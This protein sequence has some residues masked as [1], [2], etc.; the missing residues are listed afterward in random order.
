MGDFWRSQPMKLI[1]L[2]IQLDAATATVDE[3]GQLGMI[4]F[5]DLNPHVN[6]FQRNFVAQVKAADEMARKLR[7][8][9]KHIQ[10]MNREADDEEGCPIIEIDSG[11]IPVI[12]PTIGDLANQLDELEAELVD[13]NT[14]YE[15]MVRRNNRYVEYKHV[16]NKNADFFAEASADDLNFG[17]EDVYYDEDHMKGMLS[18]K[19]GVIERKSFHLFQQ[20]IFRASRGN[21]F[22]KFA[23]I[24]EQLKDPSTGDMQEKNVFIIFFQASDVL[25]EKIN[26]IC[27]SFTA[28]LYHVP[29]SREERME[30]IDDAEE[31]LQDLRVALSRTRTARY[32]LLVKIAQDIKY[33]NERVIKEK[34]IHHTMNKFN[35]DLG[36]KCLIA[37]GW[38]PA[39]SLDSIHIALRR[40][41]QKSNTD[42]DSS[43]FQ[44]ISTRDTP[45]TYFETNKF[46]Y[47][48]QAIVNSYGVPRYREINPAV[49]TCITFP[50]QF[51]VMFG[52]V[53]HGILMLLIALYMLYKEK[54][55][56]KKGIPEMFEMV[57]AGRYIIFLMALFSIYC[58]A[59]YNEFFSVPMDLFGTNWYLNGNVTYWYTPNRAY[60]F[61]VDPVWKGA[62]NELLYYNSLKMKM[63]VILGVTHMLTGLLFKAMNGVYF[64]KKEDIWFEFLPQLLFLSSVFGYLCFLIF[65]KWTI[66][67]IENDQSHDSP[68]TTQSAPLLLNVL[69]YMF[70]PTKNDTQALYS[71][72]G[73]VQ[74]ILAI[75]ALICIPWMLIPK[76]LYLWWKANKQDAY[77]PLGQNEDSESGSDSHDEHDM[78]EIVVHQSLETIEF[79]LSTISHTASY[80]RLWALSL[81]H[82]ELSTVFWEMMFAP[83]LSLGIITGHPYLSIIGGI[84]GFAAWFVAT[85]LVLMGMESLSAFLHALRLHWVE[86]Q[87]KF[88]FGDGKEFIPFS[89]E[90][91]LNGDDEEI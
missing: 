65:F 43:F 40:A 3:L 17:D 75:L 23:E 79:V 4:Q 44:E 2:F 15:T 78:G 1:R 32:Q 61:G 53:G 14:Y 64:D 25:E 39:N 69:I 59:I 60:P 11:R 76:P 16:L 48:F 35:Y 13:T 87:S 10:D 81:A 47:G 70:L 49:F 42:V 66:P 24:D 83:A 12:E 41:R 22:M 36:R 62:D 6:A 37:E 58:G 20:I 51:G 19:S 89:F 72:Q 67:F 85:M 18:W 71:G 38:C 68:L 31:Q 21:V 74:G 8:F 90:R 52:D 63:S 56:I 46:T 80:L 82:S 9:E 73:I 45:P 27:E 34:S 30:K 29:E 77:N 5:K 7:K 50:F 54:E 55:L 86:F 28:T 57:F 88:Y 91:I 33:W 26:R 84:I